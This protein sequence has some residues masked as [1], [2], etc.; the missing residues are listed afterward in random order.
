VDTDLVSESYVVS[1]P[2]SFAGSAQRIWHIARNREG[3]SLDG[4]VTLAL[5]AVVLAWAGVQETRS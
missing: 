5:L 2:R 4:F 3:W 1:A